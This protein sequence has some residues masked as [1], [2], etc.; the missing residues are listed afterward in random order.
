MKTISESRILVS[1]PFY[2]IGTRI[3]YL[4]ETVRSI[5]SIGALDLECVLYVLEGDLLDRDNF[6]SEVKKASGRMS[7]SVYFTSKLSHPFLLTWCHKELIVSRFL[8][9]PDLDYFI[10][11]E[12]DILFAEHQMNYFFQNVVSLRRYGLIPSFMRREYSQR[13]GC[14]VSTDR[15]KNHV[16]VCAELHDEG[17]RFVSHGFP[18]CAMYV[19]DRGLAK[20]YVAS[21]SFTL[22]G[23]VER[24]HWGV[25]ERAAMGLC[26]ERVPAG[27]YSRYVLQVD[28]QLRPVAGCL[29]HHA[30]NNYAAEPDGEFGRYSLETA[31][32]A[33][34]SI[35]P[36]VI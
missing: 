34:A 2:N 20:E 17:Q 16:P 4:L 31:L 35:S 19:L 30:P 15:K 1:I 3:G 36:R 18:Y 28:S 9:N 13:L 23:S 11:C 24:S 25:R 8:A 14:W 12:D 22:E 5:A 33:P 6:Q 7:V 21:R 26:F 29:I 27:F 10:Y 32:V